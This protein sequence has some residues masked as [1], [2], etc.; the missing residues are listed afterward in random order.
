MRDDN[1]LKL[2][3]LFRFVGLQ[4]LMRPLAFL[5]LFFLPLRIVLSAESSQTPIYQSE[6]RDG[7][8]LLFCKVRVQGSETEHLFF[9]DTGA[10]SCVFD[11]NIF[12]DL[13]DSSGVDPRKLRLRDSFGN[14]AFVPKSKP[15]VVQIGNEAFTTE[16]NPMLDMYIVRQVTGLNVVGVLGMS[17]LGKLML[18]L[19]FPNGVMTLRK[20]MPVGSFARDVYIR[21]LPAMARVVDVEIGG[22]PLALRIDTGSTSWLDLRTNV[23]DQFL[24]SKVIQLSGETHFDISY[25]TSKEVK[26]GRFTSGIVFSTPL[27]GVPVNRGELDCIGLS[28]LRSTHCV[29]DFP[30]SRFYWTPREK[31]RGLL[32]PDEMLG[33]PVQFQDGKAKIAGVLSGEKYP[34]SSLPIKRGDELVTLGEI[35]GRNLNLAALYDFCRD[36]AG[37]EVSLKVDRDGESVF[38]G[39]IRLR[40]AVYQLDP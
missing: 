35:Q 40:E 30:N 8:A 19:D 37:K 6:I 15:V 9:V 28:F 39:S 24:K 13:V 29:F 31:Y 12:K 16:I 25:K 38:A 4:K 2:A 21:K 33:M 5:F 17:V 22:V 34:C 10:S 1:H 32:M 3:T 20:Q 26:E 18:E 36:H 11:V 7:D 23:F 27:K 14:R